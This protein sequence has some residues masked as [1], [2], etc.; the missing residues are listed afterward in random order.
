MKGCDRNTVC[1]AE[2]SRDDQAQTVFEEDIQTCL[3]RRTGPHLKFGPGKG[4][5]IW[6]VSV[7]RVCARGGRIPSIG[8]DRS[9]HSRQLRVR[10]IEHF[11]RT[12][13]LRDQKNDSATI[14]HFLYR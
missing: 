9:R 4:S 13:M 2:R 1:L 5:V 10:V 11:C 14:L 8:L 7:P 3:R 6:T 12:Q